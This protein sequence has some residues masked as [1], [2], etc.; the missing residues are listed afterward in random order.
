MIQR[1]LVRKWRPYSIEQ[2]GAA[3]GM[4]KKLCRLLIIAAFSGLFNS[5]VKGL[6]WFVEGKMFFFSV[7]RAPLSFS[8]PLPPPPIF[9][10]NFLLHK[11]RHPSLERHGLSPDF[12]VRLLPLIS[13]KFLFPNRHHVFWIRSSLDQPNW[14]TFCGSHRAKE[15]SNRS[16]VD[17]WCRRRRI[18]RRFWAT[19]RRHRCSNSRCRWNR[20]RPEV[21]G[22][23]R[24]DCTA[25]RPICGRCARLCSASPGAKA[26]SRRPARRRWL[27]RWNFSLASHRKR[28]ANS[29]SVPANWRLR[30]ASRRHRPRTT[31]TTTTISRPLQPSL[32]LR[33]RQH[34]RQTWSLPVRR[35]VEW[36]IWVAA[37]AALCAASQ[38]RQTRR[39]RICSTITTSRKRIANHRR[40]G[41][42]RRGCPVRMA[43]IH[44]LPI[45]AETF[46][47]R[48][49]SIERPWLRHP[50]GFSPH[51]V[52]VY[53]LFAHWNSNEAMPLGSRRVHDRR[54]DLTWNI[55]PII[56]SS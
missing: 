55:Y 6:G 35:R 56:L 48:I 11:Q 54:L 27:R 32:R 2:S 23:R 20:S 15:W 30:A 45:G 16:P 24:S 4:K 34:L 40:I 10:R 26:K 3:R 5:L 28:S 12:H 43:S 22:R 36:P 25:A 17:R 8:F 52:S 41:R 14:R 18:R 53:F 50:A 49:F 29:N 21:V 38:R 13:W 39:R 1:V 46:S 51:C 33:R 42:H 31:T 9:R 47:T 44:W 37:L 19:D 7:Y